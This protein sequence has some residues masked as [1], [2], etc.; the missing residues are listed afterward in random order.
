MFTRSSAFIRPMSR[1]RS[2]T[3]FQHCA[4]LA[5]HPKVAA[6]GETGLDYHHLPSGELRPLRAIAALQADV[7]QDA[8]AAV[9]GR[10][11]QVGAERRRFVSA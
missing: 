7:A 6:I 2:R 4:C 8:E 1:M 3:F 5:E 11:L 10:G 9:T